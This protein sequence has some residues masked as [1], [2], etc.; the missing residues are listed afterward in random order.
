MSF[1]VGMASGCGFAAGTKGCLNGG[2]E[3]LIS[4]DNP[5]PWHQVSAAG[6]TKTD[7]SDPA[8]LHPVTDC[9]ICVPLSLAAGIPD[10]SAQILGDVRFA[11]VATGLAGMTL[12]PELPP[13]RSD[14]F[15]A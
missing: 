9:A 13:P 12:S 11:S 4:G 3:L 1:L 5:C 15:F 6:T 2:C 10:R 14:W 8:A 7:G